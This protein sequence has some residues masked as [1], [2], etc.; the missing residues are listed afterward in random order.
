MCVTHKIKI[1]QRWTLDR[2]ADRTYAARNMKKARTYRT[3][4]WRHGKWVRR[5]LGLGQPV[6]QR[7]EPCSTCC[8]IRRRGHST[9]QSVL[10]RI[11]PTWRSILSVQ[12]LTR[13]KRDFRFVSSVKTSRLVVFSQIR[14]SHV[15]ERA[16]NSSVSNGRDLRWFSPTILSKA[17]SK[18]DDLNVV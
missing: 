15:S 13:A 6:R 5:S 8:S 2:D 9:V 16:G 3:V 17:L 12:N 10:L 7:T 18:P 4:H 1:P 14:L 11:V